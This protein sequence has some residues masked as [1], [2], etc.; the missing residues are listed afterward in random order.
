MSNNLS[1]DPRSRVF[2]QSVKDN[3]WPLRHIL[4]AIMLGIL[5]GIMLFLDLDKLSVRIW[6]ESRLAVNALEMTLNGNYL[7][8]HYNGQPDM[9]NTK[10]PLQIW[11]IA[12]S[13]HFFGYNEWALR[14][15]SAVSSLLTVAI[16]F[17]FCR[18]YFGSLKLAYGSSFVLLVS[19]GFIG[20][21][22]SR[23]GDYD[24]MLVLFVTCLTLSYFMYLHTESHRQKYLWI[25]GGALALAVL[26]KGVAGAMCLPA[27]LLYTI[28]QK[29]FKSVFASPQ[30][31]VVL[32]TCSGAIIGYYLLREQ[33]NPGY[34]KAVVEN[35]LTGRY[36]TVLEN[37]KH[38]P[39]FYAKQL[40][41]RRYLP[42]VYL[43][44]ACLVFAWSSFNQQIRFFARYSAIYLACYFFIIS[45]AKTIH[46]WYDAPLYPIAAIFVAVGIFEITNKLLAQPPFDKRFLSLSIGSAVAMLFILGFS[47]T[48]FE[49]NRDLREE[50]PKFR[51]GYYLKEL[52]N[53]QQH[54]GKITIIDS[55]R[56]SEYD[57][58]NAALNFYVKAASHQGFSIDLKDLE[59]PLKVQD[60]VS[61]CRPDI[62]HSLSQ[63]YSLQ[64]VHTAYGCG[65][66][67]VTAIKPVFL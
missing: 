23:T 62:N 34:L 49:V 40:L 55:K 67:R 10:P 59:F 58:Y 63:R 25:A 47:C 11:A 42:W 27:L 18:Y 24:A 26:T 45:S 20:E 13:M 17:S 6:D 56:I 35:E 28:W 57:D 31:Y 50:V 1:L 66:A 39:L 7:V 16:V 32:L 36:L 29:R 52:L 4:S 8:T 2:I 9:W 5:C 33:Y 65:T 19:R 60:I 21:H 12:V 41:T 48:Y 14:F 15:P 54:L 43:L 38:S 64:W 30:L 61:S 37:E 46:Y 53:N 44:P 22:V 51:Y 3:F